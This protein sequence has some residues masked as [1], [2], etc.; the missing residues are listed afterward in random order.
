[1]APPI[2]LSVTCYL[3]RDKVTHLWTAISADVDDCRVTCAEPEDTL[4]RIQSLALEKLA[5]KVMSEQGL[6][7]NLQVD[8]K[9]M[10]VPEEEALRLTRAEYRPYYG[11]E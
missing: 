2:V 10:V 6:S 4:R 3:Y 1:V 5:Q 7:N 11:V 8:I 9:V